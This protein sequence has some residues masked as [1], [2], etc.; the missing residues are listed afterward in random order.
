MLIQIMLFCREVFW[1]LI[2]YYYCITIWLFHILLGIES[3]VWE[4]HGSR[5]RW[6][7]FITS[8]PRRGGVRDR[9]GLQP[10]CTVRTYPVLSGPALYCQDLPCTVRTCPVLSGPTLY[11]QDQP[12]TVRTN[13]VLSG[14]TLYCQ[15]L[16][17]T[18]RTYPV[19]SGPTLYC[20]DLTYTVRT[21]PVLS[22]PNLYCQDLPCGL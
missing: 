5:Y 8:W 2:G 3:T 18:V 7:T 9:E 16:P 1:G 13:P 21:Y 20:Q 15:D 12:C 6:A 11:C 10:V 14:P 4:D 22:G 19:L 17:C